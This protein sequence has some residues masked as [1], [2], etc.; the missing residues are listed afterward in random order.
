[1]PDPLPARVPGVY[2]DTELV[3]E[4]YQQHVLLVL[5]QFFDEQLVEPSSLKHYYEQCHHLVRRYGVRTPDQFKHSIELLRAA[6]DKALTMLEEKP[7][8]TP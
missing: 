2:S 1:M 8:P 4:A 6:R 5:C 7:C 3:Q